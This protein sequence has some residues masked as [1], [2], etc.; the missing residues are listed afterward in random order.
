MEGACTEL[1]VHDFLTEWGYKK[2]LEHSQFEKEGVS[3]KDV[4]YL[5]A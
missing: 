2:T 1:Q 4:I 3:Y 5:R